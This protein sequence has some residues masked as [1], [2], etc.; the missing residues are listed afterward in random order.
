[1]EFFLLIILRRLRGHKMGNEEDIK[2]L[3][4]ARDKVAEVYKSQATDDAKDNGNLTHLNNSI[5][6][7]NETIIKI[8]KLG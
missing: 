2:K 5:L 8:E 7:L 6:T 4:D 3:K 1:M